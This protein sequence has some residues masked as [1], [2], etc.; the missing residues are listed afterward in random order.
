MDHP[1]T[2]TET[3]TH[4]NRRWMYLALAAVALVGIVVSA[5][6]MRGPSGK[7]APDIVE[8]HAALKAEGE[9]SLGLIDKALAEKKLDAE[10]AL[11]Y[12]VYSA[13]G[14]ERLPE[15]YRSN[16]LYY[17]GTAAVEDMVERWDSLSK[18]TKAL[19]EPYR[20]RPEEE[21]SWV[22]LKFG[23]AE[24]KPTSLLYDN[25]YATR[26]TAYTEFFTAA[27]GKVKIWYPS[28]S[29]TMNNI[30]NP[31]TTPV[32]AVI[33][34]AMAKRIKWFLDNDGIMASFEGLMQRQLLSD[35]TRGGDG[36]LD[37]YVAPCGKDLGLA[38]AEFNPPTPSYIIIN[39]GIGANRGSLL[40][41]TLSHEIFHTFQYTHQYT[42]SKER[43]WAEATAVWSEDFIYPEVNS[44]QDWAEDY[45]KYPMA[46]LTA[47][48]PPPEHNYSAYLFP[49]YVVSNDSPDFVRKS[50]LGCKKGCLEEID[51]L[52]NGGFK[53][54]WKEFTLWNYNQDPAQYYMDWGP[55]PNY[56]SASAT[57]TSTDM[58]T[59]PEEMP[60]EFEALNPLTADL[61][62]STN[63]L[64][65]ETTKK[66]TYKNLRNFTGLS[67]KAGLKAVIYYKNGKSEVEDWSKKDTRSFCIEKPDENFDRVVLIAS[68]GDM[69][70]S[71]S[72][73]QITTVGS[74]NCYTIEQE[75]QAS[76]TLHFP[77]LDSGA[78][79]IVNI[80]STITVKSMGDPVAKAKPDQ[81]YGYLTQW[82]VLHEFEQVRGA[83]SP[84]C[85][86]STVDYPAGWTTRTAGTL[87]FDLGSLDEN[88]TFAID[89]S[90]G[91]PHPKGSVEEIPTAN[92]KC[93]GAIFPGGKM[94]MS[95][96][97]GTVKNQYRGKIFDM[98]SSGAKIEIPNC[99]FYNSC[100]M[101]DG[102]PFQT[103]TGKII[104]EIK[105]GSGK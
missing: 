30:Y 100:A 17:E 65:D 2:H 33:G 84:Q 22:N 12:K 49:F 93:V 88:G 50:W 23:D 9:T 44:E 78:R 6:L 67:D 11:V 56:S 76:A 101:A 81:K 19:L 96:Y 21:G 85:D 20:K 4:K 89:Y 99:C 34:E 7:L 26:A 52:L 41:T 74:D 69:K 72:K 5:L 105:R 29:G 97:K 95:A 77:Y 60:I 25:A 70:K 46:T 39:Y 36:K 13:F 98:T 64:E 47:L 66:I 54:Q 68:N 94:D 8:L 38:F 62:V 59:I 55:F 27:D 31:G 73:S 28:V 24:A 43:W 103:M 87:D 61:T 57:T 92:A 102:S 71:L 32:N 1:H 40:K 53:K 79:K 10:T 16:K 48:T 35:G 63:S 14:D 58:I 3:H 86:G 45:L 91:L 80:P 15:A 83:F 18:K 75:N 42:L 37:I 90:Y 104:L 82:S 51:P